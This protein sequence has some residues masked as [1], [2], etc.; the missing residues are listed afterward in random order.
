MLH[1]YT[2]EQVEALTAAADR[3][4]DGRA[5]RIAAR[6]VGWLADC[7]SSAHRASLDAYYAGERE[8]PWPDEPMPRAAESYV[9][10]GAA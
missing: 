1:T 7:G 10:A 8:T 3:R 2:R 9:P 6:Q 4:A 5:M